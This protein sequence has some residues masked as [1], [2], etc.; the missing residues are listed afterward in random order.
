MNLAPSILE[1]YIY[2][3]DPTMGGYPITNYIKP[4]YQ[5]GSI[6]TDRFKDLVIPIGLVLYSGQQ[7]MQ[8]KCKQCKVH[9]VI[10]DDAFENLFNKIHHKRPKY[11]RNNKT[12]KN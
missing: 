4:N 6:G 5:S 3:S 1:E 9:D 2:Q 12:R 8:P 11:T 10:S 7:D